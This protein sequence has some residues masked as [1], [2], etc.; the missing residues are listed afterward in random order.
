MRSMLIFLAIA[1][2]WAIPSS[3]AAQG[4]SVP[5]LRGRA[6]GATYD[7]FISEGD[8]LSAF[9]FRYSGLSPG[10]LGP[11]IGLSL[12]PQLLPAA[13]LLMAPDFGVAYNLAIP[14]A[15]L[16]LKAGGSGIVGLGRWLAVFRPGFH[17][18][19]GIIVRLDHGT[20]MRLD[21]TRHVYLVDGEADPIWSVGVGFTILPGARRG[22]APGPTR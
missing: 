6:Q 19:A 2:G 13:T 15:T 7:R 10:R 12:F 4:D 21:V 20:G 14:R 1:G 3:L 11:E 18:G 17:L 22:P 5:L 9:S 16:L 8:D